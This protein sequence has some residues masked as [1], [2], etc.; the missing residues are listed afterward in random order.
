[1]FQLHHKMTGK[2]NACACGLQPKLI[3]TL[4]K[5]LFHLECNPCGV[6]TRKLPSRSDAV[7]A[8]EEQ[9]TE[10]FVVRK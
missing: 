5:S 8:W 7:M 9:S 3:E 2:L 4:G 6:R 1:M 10:R